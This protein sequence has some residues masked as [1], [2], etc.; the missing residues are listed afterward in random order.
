MKKTKKNKMT[1]GENSEI[2][3]FLESVKGTMIGLLKI[4]HLILLTWFAKYLI[5]LFKLE[6]DLIVKSLN[7]ISGVFG[8][9]NLILAL[10]FP[11]I[12]LTKL[13]WRNIKNGKKKE[14]RKN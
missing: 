9:I 14:Q 5:G 2:K 1:K 10:T 4:F 3:F 6:N 7:I 8:I 12:R 13:I 11:I